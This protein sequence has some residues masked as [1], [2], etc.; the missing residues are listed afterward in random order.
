M[1]RILNSISSME[2]ME[3]MEQRLRIINFIRETV[4]FSPALK[5]AAWSKK[6]I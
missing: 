5:G 4:R 2:D 3:I 6:L 1:L